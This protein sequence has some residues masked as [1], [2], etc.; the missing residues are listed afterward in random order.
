M[1]DYR[2]AMT[3]YYVRVVNDGVSIVE[4]SGPSTRP[5]HTR[6]SCRRN[7][8]LIY[9]DPGED[10]MT[11]LRRRF[12]GAAFQVAAWSR[13]ILPAQGTTQQR[14]A[15][16]QHRLL[17]R[18]MQFD[19]GGTDGLLTQ[20]WRELDSNLY[21]AFPVKWSFLVF[22]RFF[23]RSGKGRSSSRRLRCSIPGT[24]PATSQLDWLSS[25]TAMIVLFWSRATRDL[26]KACPGESRGRL[27]GA[28]GHSIGYMQ[29]RSC[30][31]LYLWLALGWIVV[32]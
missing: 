19:F 9:A 27:A 24:T 2:I 16:V 5:W 15:R 32:S 23:V 29:R 6:T 28:S 18:S 21:G 20:R 3:D 7:S 11:T 17:S 26:L 8:A 22:C 25:T 1:T 4:K 31:S 10:M 30:H 14:S 12:T 13:R